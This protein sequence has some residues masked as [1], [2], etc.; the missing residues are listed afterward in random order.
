MPRLLHVGAINVCTS[1]FAFHFVGGFFSREA[2]HGFKG[3]WAEYVACR[4]FAQL[5]L[6]AA[7]VCALGCSYGPRVLV[8]CRVRA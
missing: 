6:L 7:T 1:V 8:R 5:M 3:F 4:L 2:H